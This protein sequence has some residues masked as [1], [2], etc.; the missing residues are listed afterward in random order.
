MPFCAVVGRWIEEAHYG[1][2]TGTTS[3]YSMIAF[4][5]RRPMKSPSIMFMIS[6]IAVSYDLL[7]FT[8]VGRPFV[9]G[10]A[11]LSCSRW[12][13]LEQGKQSKHLEFDPFRINIPGW[14]SKLIPRIGD[15]R[16]SSF[17]FGH[18]T[19]DRDISLFGWIEK[20]TR[21]KKKYILGFIFAMWASGNLVLETTGSWNWNF[22]PA[23][24]STTSPSQAHC[25]LRR[26][27]TKHRYSPTT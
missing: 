24:P 5:L 6:F 21:W 11:C 19:D 3:E 17:P 13:T 14:K 4:A 26:I 9:F 22:R 15:S 27:R 23:F 1:Y 8:S 20:S 25:S 12:S 18:A 10:L 7:K 2:P 16:R